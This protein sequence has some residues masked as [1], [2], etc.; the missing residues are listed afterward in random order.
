VQNR[1]KRIFCRILLFPLAVTLF[2]SGCGGG[3]GGGGAPAPDTTSPTINFTTPS[4]SGTLTYNADPTSLP[5]NLAVLYSDSGGLSTSTFS[6][7]FTFRGVT[8]SLTSLFSAGASSASTSSDTSPVYWTTVA[9][10]G[11]T[12]GTSIGNLPVFGVSSGSTGVLNLIDIDSTN[13]I[14]VVA[15]TSRKKINYIGTTDG[16]LKK[17]ITLSGTPTIVR[18]CPSQSKVYVAMSSSSSIL[19]YSLPGGALSGTI[20]LSATPK[21]M[22][23]NTTAGKAY[24]I[25]DNSTNLSIINCS[26]NSVAS[27]TLDY[28]PQRI[29]TNNQASSK[30][31]YAGGIGSDK[32]VYQYSSTGQ[33]KI[34][35]LSALPEDIAFDS[36]QNRIAVV[37]YDANTVGIYDASSGSLSGTVSVGTRP[38][39]IKAA[40]SKFYVLNKTSD[41]VSI[42]NASAAALSGTITLSADPVGLAIDS[43]SLYVLQNLWEIASQTTATLSASIKDTSGNTGQTSITLTIN[44]VSTGGPDTPSTP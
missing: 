33:S 41:S 24:V 27:D 4:P 7:S 28:I 29:I 16:S 2:I 43:S 9:K 44:P 12:T 26:D 14:A 39:S 1:I 22:A 15:A 35:S 13:N 34:F 30:L 31:Y 20:T 42:I 19:V 6:P 32:G 10:Y 5:A 17:E 3:G 8:F 38:F 11:I 25:Y 21:S 37:D 23:V 40:Q 36:T 18:A